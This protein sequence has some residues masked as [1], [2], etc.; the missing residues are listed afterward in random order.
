M[1][2]ELTEDEYSVIGRAPADPFNRDFPFG[3]VS[4]LDP[5]KST[6]VRQ[7]LRVMADHSRHDGHPFPSKFFPSCRHTRPLDAPCLFATA[8]GGL[9]PQGA[10]QPQDLIEQSTATSAIWKVV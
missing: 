2:R 1:K 6:V 3:S 9:R 7:G 4:N 5:A 10:D 8:L